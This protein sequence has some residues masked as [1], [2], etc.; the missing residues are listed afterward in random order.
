MAGTSRVIFALIAVAA[1]TSVMTGCFRVRADVQ[2][3]VDGSAQ[4][5]LEV[6]IS[7]AL[8]SLGQGTE[9]EN[10]LEEMKKNLPEGDWRVEEL[11]EEGWRGLILKGTSPAG[12]AFLPAPEDAGANIDVK[13]VQRLFS[14]EYTVQGEIP[15]G[16]TSP[17]GATS[18][19]SL[20]SGGWI[21]QAEGVPA[22]DESAGEGGF[23]PDAL[24]GLMGAM[25][26]QPSFSLTIRAPGRIVE[27][28]GRPIGTGGAEW[29]LDMISMMSGQPQEAISVYLRT[30]LPNQQS[31]GRLADRLATERDMPDMAALIA[32]YVS[33]GL[34]PNPPKTDPLRAGLDAAAYDSAISTIVALEN[35]LGSAVAERIVRGLKLSADDVTAQHLTGTWEALADIQ[36]D[37]I[38]EVAGQAVL[39]HIKMRGR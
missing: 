31:I 23:D 13:V 12:T 22:D 15:L 9:D 34:L 29:S 30:Q 3:K 39:R 11:Q 17:M 5:V 36:E 21:A 20:Q 32:E 1:L 24:M 35:V 27:T 28:N 7:E 33:R 4:T 37:E 2:L 16:Q 19:A 8:A 26:Q 38:V 6:G 10:P 25:G 14:T 18:E